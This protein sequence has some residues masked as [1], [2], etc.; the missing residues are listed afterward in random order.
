[1]WLATTG[2]SPRK[3]RRFVADTLGEQHKSLCDAVL[4]VSE[5][6]TNAVEHTGSGDSGGRFTLTV[7]HTENWA[8]VTIADEGSDTPPCFCRVSPEATE[9]RGTEILDNYSLCWG[10]IRSADGTR[11]WF[12]VGHPVLSS[13]LP[14]DIE[15]RGLE[16][17]LAGDTGGCR[18]ELP[19][20]HGAAALT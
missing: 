15:G 6:A 18:P 20:G 10:I 3:A 17:E 11:V 4:L 2:E 14:D 16:V 12:D 1:L 5:T 19:Q 13:A 9:G 8:R 7:R